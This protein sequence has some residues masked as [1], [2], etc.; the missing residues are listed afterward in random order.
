[1]TVVVLLK[2][3]GSIFTAW[4][5]VLGGIP[6]FPGKSGSLLRQ[7]F[8]SIGTKGCSGMGAELIPAGNLTSQV[9]LHSHRA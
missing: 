9:F 3:R 7:P 1:M 6:R 4:P 2:I 5:S 8:V